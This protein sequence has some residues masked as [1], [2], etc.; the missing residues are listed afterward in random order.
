MEFERHTFQRMRPVAPAGSVTVSCSMV[1]IAL[2]AASIS[3]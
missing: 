3:G 1:R 2:I